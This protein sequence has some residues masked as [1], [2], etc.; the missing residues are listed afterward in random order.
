MSFVLTNELGEILADESIRADGKQRRNSFEKHH[1]IPGPTG[2]EEFLLKVQFPRHI[3]PSL[4]PDCKPR[5]WW[6][7]NNP[8]L[9]YEIGKRVRQF[10][11]F[12]VLRQ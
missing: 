4:F 12:L 10:R 5:V 2:I 11:Y 1:L 9:E 6:D 7:G 8:V 3:S